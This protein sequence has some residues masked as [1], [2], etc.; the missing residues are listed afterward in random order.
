MTSRQGILANQNEI[1]LDQNQISVEKE[2]I[3]YRRKRVYLLKIQGHTNQK[4]AEKIGASLST[5]EKDLKAI[6]YHVKDWYE[7]VAYGDK[8]SAFISS[9]LQIDVVLKK[10]WNIFH[11]EDNSSEARKILAQIVDTSVKK[12]QLFES[13]KHFDDYVNDQ[14]TFHSNPKSISFMDLLDDDSTGAN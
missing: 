8:K 7:E 10:L 12:V 5:I 4:I 1:T 14:I 13:T 9:I 2:K 6:R 3:E 11:N